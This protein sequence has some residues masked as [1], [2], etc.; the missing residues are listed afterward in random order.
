MI[1][2]LVKIESANA[3]HPNIA[4]IIIF[5]SIDLLSQPKLKIIVN[6]KPAKP[7]TVIAEKIRK[8]IVIGMVIID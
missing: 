1:P 3:E 4:P 2:C 7:P 5:R 8:M 6:N